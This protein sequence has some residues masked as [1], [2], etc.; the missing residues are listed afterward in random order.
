[1]NL[2]FDISIWKSPVQLNF[3]SDLLFS[4]KKFNKLTIHIIILQM[5]EGE[6]NVDFLVDFQF[7]FFVH[8]LN[9]VINNQ[10]KIL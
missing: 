9:F 5:L 4:W 8:E 10:S 3:L 1:M 2:K 7:W 6:S